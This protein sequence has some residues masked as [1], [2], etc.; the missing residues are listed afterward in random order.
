[1]YSYP[2]HAHAAPS[3]QSRAGARSPPPTPPTPP[4]P[5]PTPHGTDARPPRAQ[6]SLEGEISKESVKQ[7]M[8]RG[9]A[10][11]GDLIPWTMSQQFQESDFAA[12]SGA[13]VV[14]VAVHPDMQHMGY[15]SRAVQQLVHYY[16]G[17]VTPEPLAPSAKAS[18][19]AA[20]A[21][22]KAAK[23]GGGGG[24]GLLS[25]EIAPRCELPP[26]LLS[27]TQ[28]PAER[29]H[30]LGASFGIT[31]PLFGFWHRNGFL[32]VYLRQTK[33][34]V[35]GE[36]TAIVLRALDDSDAALPTAAAD[37]WSEAYCGDFRRRLTQLLRLS[38]RD[39]PCALALSLLEPTLN[40]TAEQVSRSEHPPCRRARIRPRR[41]PAW[42]P[43]V[44]ARV[45]AA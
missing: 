10:P 11:S 4:T 28:R 1:M 39:L 18:A 37:G 29:L 42:P 33:N 26:L 15:G 22:A 36:H 5:L 2:E 27:L 13:R 25:E 3:L 6:I 17:D 16:Q 35:T 38:M 24:G 30:W 7:A 45:A 14:R 34:E 9:E 19:A 20:K 23:A 43:C 32:P 44:A 21:A 41:R 40:P 8:S 31:E 12:L